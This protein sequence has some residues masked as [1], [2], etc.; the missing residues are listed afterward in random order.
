MAKYAKTLFN[1]NTNT[2]NIN[3]VFNNKIALST[4]ALSGIYI[5]DES[6]ILINTITSLNNLISTGN[7]DELTDTLSLTYFNQLSHDIYKNSLSSTNSQVN[8]F[9]ISS[10]TALM[11]TTYN[12]SHNTNFI[13]RYKNSH[14]ILNDIEL[15]KEYLK[16]IKAQK[17][18]LSVFPQTKITV[19]PASL[20]QEYQL[21]VEQ[22]G[23]PANGLFDAN[24]LGQ[25]VYNF[26]VQTEA[27]AA[28]TASLIYNPTTNDS[29]LSPLV[30]TDLSLNIIYTLDDNLLTLPTIMP[31]GPTGP[32]G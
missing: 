31:S 8:K 11:Q 9:I 26:N 29:V 32:T 20:K 16:G 30:S 12:H 2:N 6:L 13:L 23:F 10:L 25:I 5:N 24:L 7:H 27:E 21:Y 19:A 4:S 15:L 3:S 17:E 1:T 14:D 18:Q 22:Y 28:A